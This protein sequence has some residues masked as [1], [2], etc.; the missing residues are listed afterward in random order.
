[1][2]EI[3]QGPEADAIDMNAIDMR[4]QIRGCRSVQQ[5]TFVGGLAA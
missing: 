2:C 3:Y 1:M 5:T 4:M